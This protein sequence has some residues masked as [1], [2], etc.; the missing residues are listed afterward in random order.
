MKFWR[1]LTRMWRQRN[2]PSHPRH[3]KRQP[4]RH[5][6]GS[7]V[8]GFPARSSGRTA[9]KR[10]RKIFKGMAESPLMRGYAICWHGTPNAANA[11][12]IVRHGFMIGQGNGLADGVYFSRK[13]ATAK[14]YA[15]GGGVLVKCRV[16]LGKSCLWN[17]HLQ[18]RFA[19]WCQSRGVP[20][21]NS[22]KTAYLL[23]HRYDTL[24]ANDVIVVLSPQYVNGAAW[25]RKDPRVR[26]LSVHR[27]ADG[28]R[29]KV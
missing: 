18:R 23:Q 22:G 19:Q 24:Q 14:T 26:V 6:G 9:F 20:P 11:S 7:R 27:A 21:D 10:L 1:Q 25:K 8:R 29:I 13:V 2:A 4:P 16:R 15:G 17:N 12:S 5:D 28:A 3:R